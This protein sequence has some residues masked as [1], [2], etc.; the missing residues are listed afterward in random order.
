MYLATTS[1]PTPDAPVMRTVDDT[2]DTLCISAITLSIAGCMQP[3]LLARDLPRSSRA[4]RIDRSRS[5]VSGWLRSGFAERAPRLMDRRSD[6]AL[7]LLTARDEFARKVD[8]VNARTGQSLN[9]THA[10]ALSWR[11]HMPARPD[12]A[13]RRPGLQD[14]RAVNAAPAERELTG[15]R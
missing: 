1:L 9:H 11:R 6:L 7:R 14:S 12:A 5:L 8:L 13:S 3:C 15:E 4:D 2:L 10:A